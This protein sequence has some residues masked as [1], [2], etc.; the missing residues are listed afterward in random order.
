MN[1]VRLVNEWYPDLVT[2]QDLLNLEK[3]VLTALEFDLS[4]ET[5]VNFL[6][7]FITLFNLEVMACKSFDDQSKAMEIFK[8]SRYLSRFILRDAK[9]LDFKPSTLAAACFI[10]TFN[11]TYCESSNGL[12]NE[13]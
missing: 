1:L 9:F 5:T 3:E 11:T 7:R 13:F 4:I 8:N 10:L 2:A 6:D 12:G